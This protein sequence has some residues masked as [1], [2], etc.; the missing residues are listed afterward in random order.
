[1][2][3]SRIPVHVSFQW[4]PSHV[5]I[6][7]N[8][9]ADDLAKTPAD[10]GPVNSSVESISSLKCIAKASI[11]DTWTKQWEEDT[12]GRK[13]F[14]I[15]PKPNKTRY[16]S[17]SRREQVTISRIRLGHFPCQNYLARF[18]LADNTSCLLCGNEDEDIEHIRLHCTEL[19][20]A[21]SFDNNQSLEQILENS[22]GEWKSIQKLTKMRQM[23]IH[24][25]TSKSDA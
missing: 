4:I 23:K 1:M 16:T 8:E 2:I 5:G 7:G 18:N 11:K 17:L 9:R 14:D 13:F 22:Y 19:S 12:K 21:R 15:Q 25:R 10:S 24:A 3:L 20:D 6:R